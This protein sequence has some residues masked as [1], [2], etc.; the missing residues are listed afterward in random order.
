MS[1]KSNLI[2]KITNKISDIPE[3]D[4]K[5]VFPDVLENYNY[6]KAL[7]ESSF[8][9]FSFFYIM[10]YDN[11]IPVGATACFL[12]DFPLDI[13]VTGVLKFFLN[14]VKKPFP[15]ILNCRSIM[16][17]LPMGQGRIGI[18]ANNKDAFDSIVNA[19]NKLAKV[20]KASAVIFK[21]FIESYDGMLKP[22]LD[23]GY[24]KLESLPSTDME[25]NFS[26]FEDYLK[27]L[28]KSSKDNLRRNLKKVDEKVKIDLI[29]KNHLDTDELRDVY[30]LYLQT[31]KKQ[32]LGLEK[33]PKEFF[34]AVP[35]NMPQES[36]FFLWKV[37]GKLVSFAL[38]LT[39]G[40][41]FIDYYLGFDYSLAH[42]YFLYFVRFRDLMAWCIEHGIK[43]YEM[44]VTT[45]EPK[46]RLKFNF[47][48]LYFY[49]K[50]RN[51]LINYFA[52]LISHFLKPSN[53]DPIFEHMDNTVALQDKKN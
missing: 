16:C 29:V 34:S 43:K 13:T 9:G 36:K 6:F 25:I 52:G 45:Y 51:K 4:W 1:C 40:S 47:I 20:N 19:L 53:F 14:I 35:R 8:E 15:N 48:R 17:G 7:D 39:D 3:N 11:N 42:E 21:D 18:T 23:R 41:Y 33:L 12:M 22:L 49:I 38:C 28:S 31:Y 50:H 27:I 44:G 30:E 37:R 24:I 2:T 46:R 26:N 32:D 10:I 5:K